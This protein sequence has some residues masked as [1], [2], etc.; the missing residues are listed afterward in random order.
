MSD[1]PQSVEFLKSMI[2]DKKGDTSPH[3]RALVGGAK[4]VLDSVVPGHSTKN[5]VPIWNRNKMEVLQAM[6]QAFAYE[7]SGRPKGGGL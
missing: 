5:A 3:V 6:A 4:A 2:E 1:Y 7:L